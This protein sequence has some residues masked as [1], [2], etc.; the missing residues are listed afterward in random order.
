MKFLCISAKNPELLMPQL[1]MTSPLL[2]VL[3]LPL[4]VL[5][6]LTSLLMYTPLHLLASVMFLLLLVLLSNLVLG[7]LESLLLPVSSVAACIPTYADFPA[8]AGVVGFALGPVVAFGIL[9]LC[10][11]GCATRFRFRSETDEMEAK[12]I[13]LRSKKS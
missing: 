12:L 8:S 4:L 13:S 3:L 6:L 1:F 7:S 10:D 2:L 11:V 5:L 9:L